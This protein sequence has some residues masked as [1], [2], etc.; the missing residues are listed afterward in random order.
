[1]KPTGRR[2]RS[3]ILAHLLLLGLWVL[4][5][6]WAG[7]NLSRLETGVVAL[8]LSSLFSIGFGRRRAQRFEK[9]GQISSRVDRIIDTATFATVASFLAVTVWTGPRHDYILYLEFWQ[10]V[11]LGGDPWYLAQTYWGLQP[12]NAYGPIFNLFAIPANL[13]WLYPKLIF[14]FAYIAWAMTLIEKLKPRCGSSRL[15]ILAVMAWAWNPFAWIEVAIRGHFD[16]LVGLAS[17]VAIGEIRRNRERPASYALASGVLLKYIPITLIPFL[18]IDGKRIRFRFAA[19]CVGLIA[20]VMGLSC[21]LWGRSTFYPLSFAARRSSTYLSIFRFLRGQFSP[22][23]QL[24]ISTDL[25]FLSLPLLAASL[26]IA[27]WWCRR[28]GATP[29]TSAC[30][31]ALLTLLLYRNGFPQ[32]QMVLLMIATDWIVETWGTRRNRFPLGV[33][34][35]SYFGWIIAFDVV[36]WWIGDSSTRF[37]DSV[38]L[39]TFMLG[40]GLVACL[41][42]S[43]PIR[44]EN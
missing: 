31:A 14:S 7:L 43:E 29:D 4:A 20:L 9:E 15:A 16:A 1:M 12:P 28:R 37:E 6:A 5:E 33:A 38:G 26:L 10:K 11:L 18:A 21:L 24:G 32:Y 13:N 42:M 41:V 22:V 2:E 35:A 30:L 36:Y 25:D 17:V 19:A 40:C 44:K 27:L 34:F 8:V 3:L 39:P 23:R